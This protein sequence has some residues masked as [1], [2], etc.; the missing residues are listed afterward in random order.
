M[1]WNTL[2]PGRP[3]RSYGIAAG[4]YVYFVHSYFCDAAPANVLATSDYGVVDL[5][6]IVGQ[7]NLVAMQFHPEKSQLVGLRLIDNFVRWVRGGAFEV[8]AA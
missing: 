8:G 7:E 4:E 1:G 6:A 5:P 2:T 3:I